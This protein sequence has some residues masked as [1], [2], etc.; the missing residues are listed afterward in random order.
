M[1]IWYSDILDILEQDYQK[2]SILENK[3]CY[4]LASFTTA[5]LR[6][7]LLEDTVISAS[8]IEIMIALE[9]LRKRSLIIIKKDRVWLNPFLYKYI[10]S[11]RICNKV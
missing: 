6:S 3:I 7:Q 10:A 4:R 5:I 8:P 9:S 2:L 11:K 1:N